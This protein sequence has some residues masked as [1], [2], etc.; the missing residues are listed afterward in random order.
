MNVGS[1]YLGAKNSGSQSLV[2]WSKTPASWFWMRPPVRWMPSLS[3]WFRTLWT[4]PQRVV[5]FWSSLTVS[6]PYGRPIS[7]ASWAMDVLL[8]LGTTV[9]MHL[10]TECLNLWCLMFVLFF[11]FSKAGTHLDLLSKG[12]LYAELIK[13]QQSNGHK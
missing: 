3:V 4:E 1:L 7:S 5:P 9:Q 10:H 11:M 13:R 6:A 12:G 8:R 2:P